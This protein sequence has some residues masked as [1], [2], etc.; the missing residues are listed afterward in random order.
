MTISD[1]PTPT[2]NDP[3]G[4]KLNSPFALPDENDMSDTS[5]VELPA[6][7]DDKEALVGRTGIDIAPEEVGR[8]HVDARRGRTGTKRNLNGIS[9]V[10]GERN[11]A[12]HRFFRCRVVNQF[13]GL[14]VASGER[15]TRCKRLTCGCL[16]REVGPQR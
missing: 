12:P 7:I 5:S 15:R 8:H 11:L 4:E 1:S 10:S 2:L 13:D 14:R 16:K 9:K 3:V 6:V